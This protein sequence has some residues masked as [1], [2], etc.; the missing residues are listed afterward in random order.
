MLSGVLA[1][2]I[3]TGVSG[4]ASDQARR[5]IGL[6]TIAVA[7][8]RV[9]VGRARTFGK[10]GSFVMQSLADEP[11]ECR[12]RFTYDRPPSGRARFSC[13]NG[14]DG[15]ARI[16]SE[17]PTLGHGRGRSSTGD[18]IELVFGYTVVEANSRLTLP[19]GKR[20]VVHESGIGLVDDPRDP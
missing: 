20:L 7:G 12:G 2:L 13:S 8:E 19:A 10:E 17:G 5:Q 6:L 14:E 3:L 11:V 9:F 4:C 18:E 15:R 16:E 1:T